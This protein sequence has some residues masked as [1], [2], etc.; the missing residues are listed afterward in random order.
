MK[1]K[2]ELARTQKNSV[3]NPRSFWFLV[4]GTLGPRQVGPLPD[5]ILT[6]L[7]YSPGTSL[8]TLNASL[9]RAEG[10][11]LCRYTAL[12]IMQRQLGGLCNLNRFPLPFSL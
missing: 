4:G 8:P 3:A 11:V 1:Y 12:V 7:I 5:E 6:C 2:N 9:V 10:Y